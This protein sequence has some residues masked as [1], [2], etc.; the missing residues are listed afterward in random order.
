MKV[1]FIQT[2]DFIFKNIDILNVNSEKELLGKIR[3]NEI[4]KILNDGE[5]EYINP[6]F[7]MYFK[8]EEG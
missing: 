7:I 5:V 2:V 3:N 1:V 4:I 8:L 6:T